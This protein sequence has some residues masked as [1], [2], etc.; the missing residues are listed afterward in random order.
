MM[1]SIAFDAGKPLRYFKLMVITVL[2]AGRIIHIQSFRTTTDSLTS[3]K[4]PIATLNFFNTIYLSL[5]DI[6]RVEEYHH[7]PLFV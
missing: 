2:L 4:G 7:P 3:K 1:C 5:L 6:K